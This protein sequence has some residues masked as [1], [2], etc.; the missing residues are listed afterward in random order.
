MNTNAMGE[1]IARIT[2]FF[3]A[4]WLIGAMVSAWLLYLLIKAA[5]REGIKESG[6]IQTWATTA[7]KERNARANDLPD[8]KAD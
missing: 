7:N 8:M 2:I 5:V 6:L 3:G 1:E 4:L